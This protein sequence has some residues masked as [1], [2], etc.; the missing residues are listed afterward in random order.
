MT[1]LDRLYCT[2]LAMGM[3]I[4]RPLS[5]IV[6]LLK[7]RGNGWWLIAGWYTLPGAK[8]ALLGWLVGARLL[9][10]ISYYI[11]VVAAATDNLV[12]LIAGNGSVVA[13]LLIGVAMTV[14][15]FWGAKGALALIP[16]Q[17]VR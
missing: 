11:V 6:Q 1:S 16:G 8:S 9:I 5:G 10:P 3:G 13:F 17:H 14:V 4:T 15:A 12:E 7:H 2:G